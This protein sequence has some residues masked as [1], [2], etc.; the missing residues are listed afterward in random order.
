MMRA[1]LSY[2]LNDSQQ[3]ILTILARKLNESGFY[4]NTTH[5]VYSVDYEIKKSN[6][7]IGILTKNSTSNNNVIHEWNFAISNRVPSILLVEDNIPINKGLSHPNIIYFNRINPNSAIQKVQNRI[8]K[9]NPPIVTQKENSEN[10]LA[11]VLGGVAVIA[12]IK[13]LSE[14]K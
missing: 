14:D 13:L 9:Y 4:V 5:S 6:L 8:K 12:L 2:S 10:A 3:Y 11:W 1:F 7:F